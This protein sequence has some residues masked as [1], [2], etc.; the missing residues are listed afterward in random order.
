MKQLIILFLL[1]ISVSCQTIDPAVQKK[2]NA[3]ENSLAPSI[4]FGDSIPKLNIEKRMKETAIQGLSIAVIRDYKIE[5]AKG[6]G[7]ADTYE[8]RKVTTDTRFQAASISKSI[9]SMGILKLVEIG[10]L[11]PEADINNYLTSWKFPYDSLSNNKKI[12]I[13]NLLSHTAGL[14]IHGFPGYEKTDTLPTLQQV[15][16]GKRPA[17]TKA[18]RSLYEPGKKFKYSGGGITIS[19]LILT[20]VT[21]SNYADW[22]QKNVLQPL[23]MSNSSYQQPPTVT[24]NLATGYYENGKPVTGKY[25]IYPEQAAAGLWT[26]PTDLAKYIIECQLALEGRSKKVLSQDMMKKRLTPYIDSNAALGVF[27]ENKNGQLYFTHNGG[28]EAFLCTSYG[29]MQGGNGVVI[30]INGENFSV[31]NELLNSV[32]MVY[33]WKGFYKPT[34]KKIVTVPKDTL[35][36]LVGNFLLEKDTLTIS[37]CG[38]NLCLQQNRQPATGYQMFF[39]DYSNFSVREVPNAFFNLIRNAAGIVEAL[40]LKQG[41]YNMRLPKIK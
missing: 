26:T 9:N 11:D 20:N 33:D 8:K 10:K 7:W 35:Q 15:L 19:Q 36:Q 32:A 5:W 6:Y 14:D 34:F 38:D 22:M 24:A 25:H 37:F 21:N 23:G 13:Y 18:V 27:I 31:I 29:S 1:P 12:S 28:N 16:D 30:M 17:N 40:Q 2:I 3:V 4:I 41:T 39:S